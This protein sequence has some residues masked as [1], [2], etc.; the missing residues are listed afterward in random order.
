ML[1]FLLSEGPVRIDGFFEKPLN[2]PR[3][4]TR[5]RQ[6]LGQGELKA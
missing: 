3:L 1:A 6:A 2:L 4:L 5:I